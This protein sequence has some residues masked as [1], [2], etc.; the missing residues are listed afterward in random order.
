MNMANMGLLKG[1]FE[2]D[3]GAV[4]QSLATGADVNASDQQGNT[5][6]H[7]AGGRGHEGICMILMYDSKRYHPFMT[8]MNNA[9]LDA[10]NGAGNTPVNFAVYYGQERVLFDIA[11]MLL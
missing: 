1:A 8:S 3:Q 7:Y 11:S 4:E 6:L 10:K 5:A 9:A 2:G